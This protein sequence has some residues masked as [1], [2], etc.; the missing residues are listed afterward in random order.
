[1]KTEIVSVANVPY[2]VTFYIGRTQQENHSV[3]DLARP[4]DIWFH[5]ADTSS[6]HVIALVPAGITRKERGKIIK[7]GALLCKQWTAKTKSLKNVEV[8]YAPLSSVKK[9]GIPGSV[10]VTNASTIIV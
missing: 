4:T 1:M 8:T 3:I 6:C 9:E 5:L 10:T 7:Q 2:P